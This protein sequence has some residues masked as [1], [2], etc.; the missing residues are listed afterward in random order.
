MAIMQ[1]CYTALTAAVP[2]LCSVRSYY[3]VQ[4][5]LFI[6]AVAKMMILWKK[7]RA[8]QSNVCEDERVNVVFLLI[9]C[10]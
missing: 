10:L 9:I 7:L 6:A 1:C 4:Y 3:I 5:L 8:F 2:C